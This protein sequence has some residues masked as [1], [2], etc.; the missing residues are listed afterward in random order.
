MTAMEPQREPAGEAIERV[1]A[2]LRELTADRAG[3]L[4]DLFALVH[5][6]LRQ[7]A[8]RQRVATGAGAT[9][10][11]TALVH[12][13]YL[14]LHDASLPGFADQRHFFAIAARAM[15]Q[16]LTD[17]ARARL[18]LKRGGGVAAQTLEDGVDFPDQSEAAQVLELG[19]A[20]DRLEASSP[21]LAQVVY[22]RFYAGLTDA[23]I[24]AALEVDEST[25]RRDWL[26]ARGWL[27]RRLGQEGAPA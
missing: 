9:L 13:A 12:E 1:A 16:V 27:F 19:H 25:V 18:A 15:R 6:E 10:S 8:H 11:T 20:L 17:A 14:K 3:S 26:K 4:S 23:E 24:S 2:L 21:R 5:G 22:L 7:V